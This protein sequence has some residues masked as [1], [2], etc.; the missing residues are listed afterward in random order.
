MYFYIFNR[1]H[2]NDRTSFLIIWNLGNQ[3]KTVSFDNAMCNLQPCNLS[4]EL[5]VVRK[6]KPEGSQKY[7][8]TFRI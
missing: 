4:N 7:V 5:M 6:I 1:T 2:P 8:I 3:R